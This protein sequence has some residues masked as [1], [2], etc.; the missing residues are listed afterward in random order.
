MEKKLDLSNHNLKSQGASAILKENPHVTEVDLS[1]NKITD[2]SFLQE[3]PNITSIDL[4]Y[5][6]IECLSGLRGL[7]NIVSLYLYNNNISEIEP[8]TTLIKLEDLSLAANRINDITPLLKIKNQLV[9]LSISHNDDLEDISCLSEFTE[10]EHLDLVLE[11]IS[12]SDII[13][14]SHLKKLRSIDLCY[15]EISEISPL[16]NLD[17]L[18][19]VILYETNVRDLSPLSGI[20]SIT[21]LHLQDTQVFDLS[22]LSGLV[23]LRDLALYGNRGIRDYSPIRSLPHYKP[24]WEYVIPKKTGESIDGIDAEPI[25]AICPQTTQML[26][27]D[28]DEASFDDGLTYQET[29]VM[30]QLGAKTGDMAVKLAFIDDERISE[31]FS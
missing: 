4:G 9:S 7:D 28:F 1:Q 16:S 5:N 11:S 27:A 20:T 24:E 12:D 3:H 31:W 8:L 25:E 26:G 6:Y 17:R 18:E 14:L 15:T 23:N 19:E 29:Q 2:I 10:L 21:K 13:V 22:P 30:E